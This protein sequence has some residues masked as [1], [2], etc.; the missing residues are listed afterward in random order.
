MSIK[1]S[2]SLI[3]KES[4][5][6][7]GAFTHNKGRLWNKEEIT[8][9]K[10]NYHNKLNSKLSSLLKRNESS[11]QHKANRL[12]LHKSKVFWK[13]NPVITNKLFKS[14]NNPM[15]NSIIRKKVINKLKEGYKE[16]KIKLSGI[17][18]KSKLGLTKKENH[19]NW[20][21]GISFEP[22]D[23]KFDKSFCN[24][25]K[26][27][28]NN[29]CMVCNALTLK[30]LCIHHIDYNKK[31]TCK[32]NCISLCNSCHV[33][34]NYNRSSWIKFFQTLMSDRYGY[35]YENNYN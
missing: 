3:A 25:I 14:K 7:R 4:Y 10:K 20:L 35:N 33:K 29:L 11:I 24:L 17:A 34:T 5:K 22:Y 13:T 21:G 2:R 9:L 8:L 27:R 15:T 18:L 12:N 28:D 30:F 23:K 19:P 1:K 16:G 31:N 26:K 32:E 6:I